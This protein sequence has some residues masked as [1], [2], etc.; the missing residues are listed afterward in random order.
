MSNSHP[1]PDVVQPSATG[2]EPEDLEALALPGGGPASPIMFTVPE[3]AE[4]VRLKGQ[5]G[6]SIA[7]SVMLTVLPGLVESVFATLDKDA[8]ADETMKA[9]KGCVGIAYSVA[10]YAVE[11]RPKL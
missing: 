3:G 8:D 6:L 11:V 4:D 7:D 9:L 10:G 5:P 2:V 1:H